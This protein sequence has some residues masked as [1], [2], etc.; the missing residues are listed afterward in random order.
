MGIAS[1]IRKILKRG[2]ARNFRKFEKK[3]EQSKKLFHLKSVRFSA[4]NNVKSKK[5]SSLEFSPIFCPKLKIICLK[6]H[7]LYVLKPSL[8]LTKEG[9]CRNFAYYSM[10]N[11]LSW[12]PKRGGPWHPLNTPLG[13]AFQL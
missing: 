11:I 9:P 12:R 6:H 7:R 1:S 4:Q 5:K 10:L 3:K 13:I 2:G 8:Q